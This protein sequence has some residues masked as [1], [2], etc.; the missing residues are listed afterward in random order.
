MSLRSFAISV[1]ASF[2]ALSGCVAQDL[3]GTTGQLGTLRFE[4]AT[5][6]VCDGCALDRQVLVGSV[7]DIE[8]HGVHPRSRYAVRSTAPGI[9]TFR[10]ISRCRFVGEENC[11]DAIAVDAKSAGDADLEVFDEWT[12]TVLD[13]VT[14]KVRDAASIDAVVRVASSEGVST[15][16]LAANAGGVVELKHNSDVAIVATARSASGEELIATSD[17]IRGA[18]A[19]EHVIGPRRD[20]PSSSATEYARANGPGRTTVSILGGA[21]RQE[22]SFVV[23][24]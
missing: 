22:L 4:Y 21:A 10:P 18:Y 2:A 12:G 17:A 20:H 16:K 5:A 3:R 9:A 8:V 11:R 6:D 13:R 14:V 1:I 19:D 15:E 24:P 23:V 7:L